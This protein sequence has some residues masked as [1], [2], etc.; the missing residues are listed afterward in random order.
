MYREWRLHDTGERHTDVITR[1]VL[2]AE[3]LTAHLAEAGFELLE[4]FPDPAH[5]KTHSH[6]SA[7]A[8]F[9]AARYRG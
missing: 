3:V 6:I 5:R 1:R 4:Q 8:I 2:P 7:R 9:T